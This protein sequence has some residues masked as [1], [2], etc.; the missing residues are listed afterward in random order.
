[1]NLPVAPVLELLARLRAHVA[2]PQVVGPTLQGERRIVPILG[3]E[4]SGPLLQGRILPGGA[5][6]QV[7]C[8][9]RT[10]LLE[11]RYTVKTDD[12][13]LVYVRNFGIRHG[14]PE[15]LDRL[16]RGEDVD[17]AE[18]YFRSSP[19]FESA[20]PRYEWLNRVVAVGS[21]SRTAS[22]VVVDLY[23]VR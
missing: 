17:P 21:G 22:E 15:V 5:D 8:A 4:V 2:E 19:R 3:G 7:V 9:D 6:W 18:Y 11:A 10:S 16:A 1:V 13:A 14:P 23:V 20:H 12:G